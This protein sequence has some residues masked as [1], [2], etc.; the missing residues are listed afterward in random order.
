MPP[1][2]SKYST[3]SELVKTG[4]GVLQGIT[5][6]PAAA[7]S[8]ATVYDSL[9]ATGTILAKLQAAADGGSV[10]AQLPAGGIPFSTGLWVELAGTGAVATTVYD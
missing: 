8:T 5:L 10:P 3:S 9:S 7:K 4:P 2:G 6:T 1:H